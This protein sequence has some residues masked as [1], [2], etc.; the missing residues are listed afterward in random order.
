MTFLLSCDTGIFFVLV[1]GQMTYYL[2]SD[3]EL[4]FSIQAVLK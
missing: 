3:M 4:L 1:W 2:G